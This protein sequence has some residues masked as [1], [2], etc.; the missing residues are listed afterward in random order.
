[1]YGK[2]RKGEVKYKAIIF[3]MDG[4]IIDTA[5]VWEKANKALVEHCGV[6]YTHALHGELSKRLGSLAL[7]QTC[8]IIKEVAC[9][10]D[11]LETLIHKKRAL[12]REL[13]SE[14]IRFIDG[15]M[16]FHA[17]VISHS[18]CTAV[19]TNA[20]EHIVSATNAALQLDRFFGN[21]IYGI[22]S[23]GNIGKPRPDIYLHAAHNLGVDPMECIA[24]ED[25]AHGIAA[26]KAAGMYCIGINTAKNRQALRE[27]DIIIEHYDDIDLMHVVGI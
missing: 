7:H 3:D 27:S 17:R 6:E 20:D 24:I 9:L 23:V 14:G 26:A 21:H 15:F 5:T 12:A 10:Q 8:A 22:D 1:M 4:T 25:S 16:E 2:N 11:P 19:A 18:L 13:F